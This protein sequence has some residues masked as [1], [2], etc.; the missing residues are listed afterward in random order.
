LAEGQAL[1]KKLG[2]GFVESSAKDN[3]NVGM[4]SCRLTPHLQT[5][6]EVSP[7][8]CLHIITLHHAPISVL[9]RVS[10]ISLTSRQS[11]RRPMR[12]DAETMEPSTREEEDR[13][14]RMVDGTSLIDSVLPST[15]TLFSFVFVLPFAL[16][17]STSPS[18]PDISFDYSHLFAFASHISISLPIETVPPPSLQT[19]HPNVSHFRLMDNTFTPIRPT[20]ISIQH[21]ID[22]ILYFT[23]RD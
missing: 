2:A 19:H 8:R 4:S 15:I 7:C 14:V 6:P 16:Y 3:T 20:N 17:L 13:L 11:I 12:R 5:I 22:S 21:R 23:P 10:W 1:A 9:F 18:T